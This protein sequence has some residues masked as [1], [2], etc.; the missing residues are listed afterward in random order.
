VLVK[1]PISYYSTNSFL[2]TQPIFRIIISMVTIV[3][4]I[5]MEKITSINTIFVNVAILVIVDIKGIVKIA[6][7][8]IIGIFPTIVTIV[9]IS[10]HCITVVVE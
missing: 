2:S 1:E 3:A 5:N 9:E 4:I 7:I 8:L 6:T 10:I